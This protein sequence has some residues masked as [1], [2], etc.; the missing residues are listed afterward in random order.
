MRGRY[1][2]VIAVGTFVFVRA[3]GLDDADTGTGTVYAG[4]GP[5]SPLPTKALEGS[6]GSATDD[7][8]GDTSDGSSGDADLSGSGLGGGSVGK[9]LRLSV[10]PLN[11]APMQ[12]INLT[13]T[14]GRHD[15]VSL[16]VQ[17]YENGTWADFPTEADVSLGTFET[18]VETSHAG[19]NK[20]RVYDAQNDVGSNVVTVTVR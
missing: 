10:T 3:L 4:S 17:R 15:N 5:A 18:F 11:V 6:G 2:V 7:D 19:P 16:Q 20:F 13:G 14:Y 12:R 8:P 9:G 1:A